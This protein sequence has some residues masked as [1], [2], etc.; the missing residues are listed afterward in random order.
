MC[1]RI[2]QIL[3]IFLLVLSAHAIRSST[4]HVSRSTVLRPININE[5]ELATGLHR[6]GSEAFSDLNPQIQA[7]LIYGTPAGVLTHVWNHRTSG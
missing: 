3:S 7:E 4:P 6:R 2:S 1:Q 5:Y